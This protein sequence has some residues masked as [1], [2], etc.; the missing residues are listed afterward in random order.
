MMARLHGGERATSGACHGAG[1]RAAVARV[2]DAR[3]PAA[4]LL[5]GVR[6]YELVEEL[7]M[8]YFV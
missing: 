6:R 1:G 3:L 7:E 5:E 8:I 4:C 2:P